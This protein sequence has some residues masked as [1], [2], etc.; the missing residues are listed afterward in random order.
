MKDIEQYQIPSIQQ[1][2]KEEPLSGDPEPPDVDAE[3]RDG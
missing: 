3:G 1:I 2:K